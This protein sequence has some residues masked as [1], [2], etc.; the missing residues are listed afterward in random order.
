MA[1]NQKPVLSYAWDVNT[2]NMQY[3]PG[4]DDGATEFVKPEINANITTHTAPTDI[5]LDENAFEDDEDVEF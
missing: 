1:N 3:V 5:P 4:E 2:G